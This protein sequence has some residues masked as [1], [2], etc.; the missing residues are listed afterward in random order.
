LTSRK[1]NRSVAKRRT[2]TGLKHSPSTESGV[3]AQSA[4]A[5]GLLPSGPSIRRVADESQ[6]LRERVAKERA[7]RYAAYLGW[8]ERPTEP[9]A[10][11]DRYLAGRER[12]KQLRI[13]AEGDSWFEYPLPWPRGDGVVFQ[14]QKL[15]G[16]PILN[17]AHHGAEVRQI[18]ALSERQ[19]IITRLSDPNV[20]YD[21][22]LF[23][24]GGNDLVGD[25]FCIWLKD[26]QPEA[27]PAEMLDDDA[28]NAA[29]SIVETGYREL[30]TIRDKHSPTTIIFAHGYDFPPITGIGVCNVGPW[31]KPSLD[32]VYRESG[33]PTPDPN[34]EFIVVKAL[35][36]RFSAMLKKLETQHAG[37]FVVVP[38]QGTL[39][40]DDSDWQNEIHPTSGGFVKIAQKF[41]AALAGVFPG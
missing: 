38:T 5:Q 29:L 17:M 7:E 11:A 34:K 40:A 8:V 15:L 3:V 30:M 2:Q 35:L 14:L 18:L 9:P 28:V 4:Q 24:G 26:I 6:M 27:P 39:T 16:Y 37:R 19:E 21:A 25:Q 1:R 33:V 41:K 13:L 32:F 22:M 10:T 23:S 36:E 12:A 20:R 31:L